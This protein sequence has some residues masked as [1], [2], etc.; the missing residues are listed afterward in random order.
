VRDAYRR[1]AQRHPLPSA[2][3]AIALTIFICATPARS[4]R[5]LNVVPQ[6]ADLEKPYPRLIRWAEWQLPKRAVVITGVLSGPFTLFSD[7]DIA[8]CDQ[9]TDDRFQILRAFAANAG[10]PWYA[11]V[12]DAESEGTTFLGRFRG[13]WNVVSQMD[14]FTLYRLD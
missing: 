3:V 6:L 11:V 7:R 1:A 8:R 12:A 10:L 14:N 13:N 9:L 4:T 5:D 2:A